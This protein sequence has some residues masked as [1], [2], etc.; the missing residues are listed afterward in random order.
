MERH[1]CYLRS[2]GPRWSHLG[3][4]PTAG[5][6]CYLRYNVPHRSHLGAV[7]S[8]MEA[9]ACLA[10]NVPAPE[11]LHKFLDVTVDSSRI[12]LSSCFLPVP[13]KMLNEGGNIFKYL[14]FSFWCNKPILVIYFGQTWKI[15]RILKSKIKQIIRNRITGSSGTWALGLPYECKIGKHSL[16]SNSATFQT[17]KVDDVHLDKHMAL[18]IYHCA[19]P[20][21]IKSAFVAK[22]PGKLLFLPLFLE[23]LSHALGSRITL[24]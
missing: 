8:C 20:V 12:K 17:P 10:N 19:L 6:D 16:Q 11:K 18:N 4:F 21:W 2:N 22:D 1:G 3:C 24:K 23:L 15:N 14:F 9:L 5:R 7:S 13:I